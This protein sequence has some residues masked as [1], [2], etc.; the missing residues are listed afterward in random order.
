MI[1]LHPVLKLP[2]DIPPIHVVDDNAGSVDQ[3]ILYILLSIP[4]Q[5]KQKLA[6]TTINIVLTYGNHI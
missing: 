6:I 3:H 1:I 4:E 5:N 2:P